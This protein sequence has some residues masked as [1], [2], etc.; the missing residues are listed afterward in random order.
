MN[1]KTS[2]AEKFV[3][4]LAAA[5]VLAGFVVDWI[6]NAEGVEPQRPISMTT[7]ANSKFTATTHL[8]R[9]TARVANTGSGHA[10]ESL[11]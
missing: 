7:M 3:S 5:I 1:T 9:T 6:P 10:G 8:H 2:R 11:Q 4:S